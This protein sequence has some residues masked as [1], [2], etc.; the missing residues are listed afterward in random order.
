MPES[1]KANYLVTKSAV[2]IFARFHEAV[3]TIR[4]KRSPDSVSHVRTLIGN[5]PEV[6]AEGLQEVFIQDQAVRLDWEIEELFL[7]NDED[8]PDDN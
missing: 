2:T 7:D 8:K 3:V 1:I 6:V 5:L 4:W